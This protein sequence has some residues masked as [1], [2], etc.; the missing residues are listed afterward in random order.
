MLLSMPLRLP[1]GGFHDRPPRVRVV[2]SKTWR[3]YAYAMGI[4]ADDTTDRARQ[5]AF[6]DGTSHLVS[7]QFVGTGMDP[8]W[9][10]RRLGVLGG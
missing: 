9:P 1:P 6:K 7:N 8:F 5:K 4:S 2:T 3:K 10:A